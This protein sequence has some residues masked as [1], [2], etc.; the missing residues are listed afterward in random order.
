MAKLHIILFMTAMAACS[1][2]ANAQTTVFDGNIMGE[3]V[4]WTGETLFEMS[5]GSFWIQAAYA[6]TYHYAYN[7]R[8]KI[9]KS[10]STHLLFVE[11]VNGQVT[12]KPLVK[13]IK[14]RIKGNFEGFSGET[15]YTLM[16]GSVWQQ[17]QYKYVYKYAYTPSV[18]IYQIGGSWK[19]QV[20]DIT[21]S[22]VKLK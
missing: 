21:V 8:A 20:G 1:F 22:V 12:V 5:D 9:V 6:Y 15:V 16:D 3:F 19:M 11:G 18:L 14:S 7:P 2:N 17:S 13:V 10:G 4:G